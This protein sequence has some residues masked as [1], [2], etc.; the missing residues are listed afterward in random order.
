[1]AIN[2]VNVPVIPDQPKMV[3]S[4]QIFVYVDKNNLAGKYHYGTAL[5]GQTIAS[6]TATGITY[7][8]KGD[9]YINTATGEMY[10]CTLAGSSVSP[11]VVA[12]WQYVMTIEGNRWYTGGNITG[13][14][15]SGLVFSGSGVAH[16]NVG[17]IY[18]NI[19]SGT[20]RG[21]MYK[22]IGAGPA[23]SAVWSYIGNVT[24]MTNST[25]TVDPI[26]QP[27]NVYVMT[28]GSG[29]NG[30]YVSGDTINLTLPLSTNM[31]NG[32]IC[33][34]DFKTGATAPTLNIT[35]NGN[36]IKYLKYGITVPA[37]IPQPNKEVNM[38]F[39][40]NGISLVCAIIEV[41]A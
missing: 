17:D 12:E 36:T 11:N 2:V 14:N 22:C 5:T 15:T 20:S 25:I 28:G 13:T 8:Y 29:T 9:I 18:L 16:A 6:G 33:E 35:L 39:R 24:N 1:M 41:D 40:Y 27:D 4:Q 21:N 32:Y 34:V 38:L 7:V 37:Y 23:T 30:A 31:Y 19:A 3:G 26:L 10:T